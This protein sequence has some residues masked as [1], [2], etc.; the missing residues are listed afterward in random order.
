MRQNEVAL[1]NI[2]ETI[3]Y[4]RNMDH[5]IQKALRKL[6]NKIRGIDPR[7]G[8]LLSV[9]GQAE[10]LIQEATSTENLSKMYIG[11]LPFW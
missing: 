1:M 11:W 9:S 6:R 3:M 8:L 2:I 7:D 5:S 10:T 4:D